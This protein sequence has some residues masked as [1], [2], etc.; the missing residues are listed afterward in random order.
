MGPACTPR[1]QRCYDSLPSV[2]DELSGYAGRF[3]KGTLRNRAIRRL[4]LLRTRSRP[5]AQRPIPQ[6]APKRSGAL[7]ARTVFKQHLTDFACLHTSI[8]SA[9]RQGAK[10]VPSR[11]RTGRPVKWAGDS[12]ALSGLSGDGGNGETLSA[13]SLSDLNLGH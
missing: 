4:S 13:S 1:N 8:N 10:N 12:I 6:T 7:N 5:D 3:T 2:N 11:Q 9:L